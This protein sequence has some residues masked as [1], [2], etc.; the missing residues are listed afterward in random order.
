MRSARVVLLWKYRFPCIDRSAYFP[1]VPCSLRNRSQSLC[2][3]RRM[4]SARRD[5]IRLRRP[6][7]KN[8]PNP[9]SPVFR[10]TRP[11]HAQNVLFRGCLAWADVHRCS[12]LGVQSDGLGQLARPVLL[13]VAAGQACPARGRLRN[14]HIADA[15]WRWRAQ[16]GRVAVCAVRYVRKAVKAETKPTRHGHRAGEAR[17]ASGQAGSGWHGRSRRSMAR[18]PRGTSPTRMRLS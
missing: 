3:C 6:R 10:S 15:F 16:P 5:R 4:E 7:L 8:P 14:Q 13:V 18:R 11:L 2:A 9:F 1:F 12:L 17:Q